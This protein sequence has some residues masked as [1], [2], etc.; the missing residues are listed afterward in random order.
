MKNS[1]ELKR[2]NVRIFRPYECKRFIEAIP[3]PEYKTM[4]QTLLYTGMRY[5]EVQRLYK[6]PEWFDG[7]FI[8]LPREADKKK[9]RTQRERTVILNPQGRMAVALFLRLKN[10][11]PSWQAWHENMRRWAVQANLSDKFLS[12]K[13]TRKTWESWMI[14]YYPDRIAEITVSQG[15]TTLTCIQHYLGIGF[16]IE[17]KMIMKEFVQGMFD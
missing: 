6:K 12:A 17:D 5:I 8:Y 9:K 2:N 11:L 3:K 14:Y 4:F 7:T 10:N 16:T 13:T 1:V 15:H